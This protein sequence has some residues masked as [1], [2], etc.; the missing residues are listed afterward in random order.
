LNS[1]AEDWRS[2]FPEL[3]ALFSGKAFW[4][5]ANSS[6]AMRVRLRNSRARMQDCEITHFIRREGK[7]TGV[8][9]FSALESHF[10]ETLKSNRFL[11]GRETSFQRKPK[12]SLSIGNWLN[13]SRQQQRSFDRRDTAPTLPG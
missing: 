8:T 3:S 12:S 4:R 6:I 9:A 13:S 1:F 2:P 11:L 5:A 7:D 10:Q